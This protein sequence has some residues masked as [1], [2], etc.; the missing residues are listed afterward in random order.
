MMTQMEK[1][2]SISKPNGEKPFYFTYP[3]FWLTG[4]SYGK[5]CIGNTKKETTQQLWHNHIKPTMQPQDT[6]H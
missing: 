6:N 3:F 2:L 1:H 5:G 4:L